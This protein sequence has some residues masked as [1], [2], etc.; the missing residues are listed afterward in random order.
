M[1]F[2][3][4]SQERV[5]EIVNESSSNFNDI[6]KRAENYFQN[7]LKSVTDN[8]QPYND[9][10]YHRYKRWEW[11]WEDRVKSDGSFPDI[12][13]KYKNYQSF[14][15]QL[16]SSNSDIQ[17]PAWENINQKTCTGGYNGMG[18]TTAIAFHPTNAD[19]FYVGAPIGGIWKT[20]DG[21][22]TYAPKGDNLPHV[23][24]GNIAINYNNPDEIYISIS[25]NSGWWNYSLGIYKSTDAG[26]TWQASG[27]EFT[28][29]E[30][31][32]I[33]TLEMNPEDPQT[34][35][36]ATEGGLWKTSDGGENWRKV[37]SDAWND[38]KYRPGDGST[39]YA[40]RYDYWGE[41]Q[42]FR[43]DNGGETWTKQSN[44]STEKTKL[45]LAVSP[46]NRNMLV[47]LRTADNAVFVSK[48]K[49]ETFVQKN[50]AKENQ[51]IY[52]SPFYESII[53]HGYT[54]V[55]QS[56]NGGKSSQKITMWYGGTGLPEIHADQQFVKYNPLNGYLYFCNDG[57]IYRYHEENNTWKEFSSGLV[58]TQYYKLA[59]AQTDPVFLIGGTQD[60]GGRMRNHDGSWTSTNGG[61]AMEVAIDPN[62]EDVFYTS[63]T[64]GKLYRTTNGWIS[65]T[66]IS[67]N[68][69]GEPEGRW[70][71]PYVL[72]PNNSNTIVAGY[73]EVFRST[74]RGNSWTKI[75]NNLTGSEDNKL[76]C[77]AVA[78]SNSDV[79][80]ASID[81]TI[82]KTSDLGNTW[83]TFNQWAHNESITSI[84]VN[85]KSAD[86]LWVS[87]GNYKR[88]T[89][90]YQSNNGGTTWSNL[91]INLPNVPV[92]SIICDTSQYYNTIYVGTDMGVFCKND[93]MKQWLYFGTGLPNTSV[94]DMDIQYETKK[95][96]ISTYGRGIWETTLY[97][98]QQNSLPNV[99]LLSPETELHVSTG[100]KVL[101]S[102]TA[103]D[104][105]GEIER[106]VFFNGPIKIGEVKEE[107]YELDLIAL[108]AGDYS[109]FARAIDNRG[110]I[111]ETQRV[112]FFV[113]CPDEGKLAG[114][115]IGTNGTWGGNATKDKALDGDPSTFFDAN[116]AKGAWVGLKLTN[117][118]T[119]Q[120]IRFYPRDGHRNRML[121][122]KF[123]ACNNES[124]TENVSTLYEIKSTPLT[125][126]NCLNVSLNQQFKY[127]RYVSP[128]NGFGN[129]AELEF[130]GTEITGDKL[131]E[132]ANDISV[133][134][135]P[136]NQEVIVKH[137]LN[138]IVITV[139]NSSGI[140]IPCQTE[141]NQN[142]TRILFPNYCKA[143][144]YYLVMQSGK[145]VY[146][147]KI[148]K[149][150]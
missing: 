133:Y 101:L 88:N 21:G 41:S 3:L 22:K 147:R 48:D 31:I 104:T 83:Q 12:L 58:I 34:L 57:G 46:A 117:K 24:V 94:T 115:I 75:S 130:Y 49:G 17:M 134:P 52:I 102:A 143:G 72:D 55:H 29:S 141:Q 38:V 91:S 27:L 136:F 18:R 93:T 8:N 26:E 44:Y 43:S 139:S 59:V 92:N 146:F 61:D 125:E 145:Q 126:W 15:Q 37:K 106:V 121:G 148:V 144:L 70:V 87:F 119:V 120:G 16:K 142:S 89:K 11:Y 50:D 35:M 116:E 63:Y 122:G 36:A 131:L 64:N 19:I 138:D 127:L 114:S 105:D 65:K 2:T 90:V 69:E 95:L 77:I 113:E 100:E 53:Y 86:T 129:I 30:G 76:K 1:S 128:D 124:F 107:P 118:K 73:Q 132:S 84:A 10:A 14:Q 71:T 45:R 51:F 111:S 149:V 110:G 42:V 96:R 7:N 13:E 74:N 5:D 123:Q 54:S 99:E 40:A 85:H 39:I 9:K 62:N 137:H 4:S 25:D 103:T 98:A 109:F 135:N 32:A 80:F 47:V 108:P 66:N 78:P 33:Y 150:N 60:N 6:K 56:K 97:G 67:R 28:F 20:T 79:I 82:Y 68:I 140:V 112:S 81:N 23:G